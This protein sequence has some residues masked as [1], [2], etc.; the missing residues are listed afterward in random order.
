MPRPAGDRAPAT[1]LPRTVT[2]AAL[3]VLLLYPVAAGVLLLTSDGWA[4]N[5]ANVRVWILVTDLVGM[6]ERISPEQFAAL[7]NVALFVPFFA[8][9]AVLRPSWWWVLLGAAASTAVELYQGSLGSRIQDP[10]DI[11]ANTLGAALGVALGML[12]RRRVLRRAG[13]R[14]PGREPSRLSAA[15]GAPG[16]PTTP[17]APPAHSADGPDGGPDDR[18]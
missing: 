4:V 11:L 3:A 12:L 15:A 9:L 17:D 18:D 8:A 7:A 6:R 16:A 14:R 2:A 13:A 5:R 10:G 1:P